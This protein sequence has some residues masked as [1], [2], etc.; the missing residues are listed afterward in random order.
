MARLTLGETE[1]ISRATLANL[2]S[3]E[4]TTVRELARQALKTRGTLIADALIDVLSHKLYSGTYL[5]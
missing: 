1:S 4:A 5:I 3:N 2:L